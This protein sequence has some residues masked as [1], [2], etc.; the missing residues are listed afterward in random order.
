MLE[1][2]T[3]NS[4][5]LNNVSL[6]VTYG[7][8][9]DFFSNESLNNRLNIPAPDLTN[10]SLNRVFQ[11]VTSSQLSTIIDYK[12]RAYPSEINTYKNIVR[13]RTKYTIANIWNDTRSER[14]PSVFVSVFTS[15]PHVNSQGAEIFGE[16]IWPLDGHL[17]FTTTYSQ[18]AGVSPSALLSTSGSGELLN[19]Y[20]R[21][22]G[23]FSGASKFIQASPVYASRVPAG[24]SSAAA[25][26]PYVYAGDAEWLAAQQSGKK[27]YE[28]YS[29]YSERI[30][31]IGKDHS[32]VPEFR[33][34]E[35]IETYI[36]TKS[37]DFL[38]DVDNIFNLT[39]ASIYDSSNS[40]FFKTYTNSDFIKYFSVVDDSLHDK[41]SEDLKIK[42]DK[43]SLSCNAMI[44]FLPYKGFYPAERTLELAT[45]LSKSYG[46]H[47]EVD[48]AGSAATRREAVYRTFLEPLVA[49]GIL[50][51]TIKSGLAVSNYVLTNTGSNDSDIK[52]NESIPTASCVQTHLP[53]GTVQYDKLLN[54]I[55][56]D[57]T[58][59]K[60]SGYQ[61]QKLPFE[62][63]QRPLAFLEKG[64]ISGSG[65]VYDTGIG[66]QDQLY[67]RHALSP[68]ISGS[69]FFKI[70]AGQKFYELAIDNFLCET[71]NFFMDGLTSFRSKREDQFHTVTS[72]SVYR[73]RA[74]LFRTLDSNLNVDRSAF[75]LYARESAFGYPIGQGLD[76]GTYAAQSASF[77][78]VVPPYYHG[79]A[80]VDF[81][82]EAPR[83]GLPTLDEI[84]SN[85]KITY[86]TTYPWDVEDKVSVN[87]GDSFNV[88]QFFTEVPEGTNEQKKV[89]LLQSKFET[90]VLNF[91][92]VTVASQPASFVDSGLSSS[93][94]IKTNGMWH[95]YGRLPTQENEGIFLRIKEGAPAGQFSLAEV[96][97]FETGVPKRIGNPK[98]AGLLEEAVIAIPFKTV[99][100]RREFFPINKDNQQYSDTVRLLQKYVFPPKFDFVI[101]QTV[102]PILMYG[103]EFSATLTQKDITD[104]WQNLPPDIGDKFEQKEVVI[105]DK[106]VLEL[107]ASDSDEIRWMVFKVKKRAQKSYDKYRRSLVTED[108]SAFPETVG[109][110]SYN[111]PYDYFSLVELVKIDETVRYI[112]EDIE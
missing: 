111:W 64:F 112:S 51:N 48:T 86:T 78:H 73:M 87:I 57:P 42:R 53:E 97:G 75:D 71:T 82:F 66:N 62:T 50:F 61:I 85:A 101:N 24:S 69:D 65:A 6:M 90:P 98:T 108:T 79:A 49:P 95:Q 3:E 102:T 93:A 72:G 55:S 81:V 27:P 37:G 63:V 74:D 31:V 100:N 15:T 14:T 8:E 11:F 21:F 40:D 23:R 22:Y 35:L 44:K 13:R 52:A 38:A 43:L 5:P 19:V 76:V 67:N 77:N 45:I 110:Y 34:S 28:E 17:D 29:S 36:D 47:I 103:F 83:T 88:A 12:E 7:N 107:L 4:D 20:S 16:S 41:R 18:Q 68:P 70:N 105:D 58:N 9:L 59:S 106:Q 104:M 84:L 94:Q 92:N 39:G 89:W 80:S 1:D 99:A 32:I 25:S 10:N 56:N 60:N 96:V 46:D 54:V 33:I 26:S 91:A 30:A 109:D 2:N